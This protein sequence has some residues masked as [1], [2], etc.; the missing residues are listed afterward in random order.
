MS[1]EARWK[2]IFNMAWGSDSKGLTINLA[3]VPDDILKLMVD[4]RNDRVEEENDQARKQH[5]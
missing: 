2:T 4:W 1:R 3:E 5:Q